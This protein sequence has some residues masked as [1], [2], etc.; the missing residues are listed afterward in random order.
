MRHWCERSLVLWY[1]F[2]G[3][4]LLSPYAFSGEELG[5]K[6]I[7]VL[8]E[9]ST[10]GGVGLGLGVIPGKRVCPNCL[11]SAWVPIARRGM[12]GRGR[13]VQ[14]GHLRYTTG[15]GRARSNTRSARD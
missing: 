5:P 15:P 3:R 6:E 4:G 11:G 2:D 13:E 1:G 14:K 10:D 9:R 12:V 8:G 7:K